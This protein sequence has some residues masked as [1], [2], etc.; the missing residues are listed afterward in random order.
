MTKKVTELPSATTPLGAADIL[1]VVQGG[2]SKQAPVS[3]LPSSGGG[4]LT[5]WAEAISTSGVN[6]PRNAASLKATGGATDIDA[7]LEPK[8]TGS[9]LAQTPTG[10]QAGG[11]KRGL[12][13]V[14]FQI[15][16][17]ISTQ[18][19]QG[20]YSVLLGGTSNTIS[21]NYGVLGG[22]ASNTVSAT[23]ATVAGGQSNGAFNTHSAVAGGFQNSASGNY[24]SI[25]GGN[26][27][28]SSGTSSSVIGGES[29]T[30][31]GVY[32]SVL[33]GSQ[34]TARGIS[35]AEARASGMFASQGDAQRRRFIQRVATSNA[36][37]TV[38]TTNGGAAGSTNLAV[39]PGSSAFG[40]SGKVVARSGTTMAAWEF[41]GAIR[42]GSGGTSD[43]TLVGTPT[44]T[45]IGADAGAASW[46][47]AIATDVTFGA[48]IIQVTGAAATNIRWVSD[49]ET[50]EVA[51]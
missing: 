15:N 51:G 8:G 5:N 48:L 12:N 42:R 23:Y 41:K 44:V 7:V 35:G 47:V 13:A 11:N 26:S 14:D 43:I 10:T 38:V 3:G 36:T 16:R 19:A 2:V 4:G 29:N 49:L 50:V 45:S 27:N 1:L 31:D 28:T 21:A 9:I 18:I 22:G 46:S 32:S 24:A 30:A 17:S 39:L 25:T 40:F 6:N 37:T 34:G 33:G 20:D